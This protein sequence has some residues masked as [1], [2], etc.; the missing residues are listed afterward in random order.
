MPTSFC[1]SRRPGSAKGC[2]PASTAASRACVACSC[3][4]RAIDPVGKARSDT[5]IVLA[6]AE[7][8]G[9]SDRFFDGD[10]D[11]GHDAALA[12]AGVNVAQLRAAPAGIVVNGP[13][14]VGR[15]C[16]RRR[17]QSARLSDAHAQDRALLGASSLVGLSPVARVRRGRRR[18]GQP[19]LSTMP[20]QRQ[21]G[22]LLPQ[23]AS[24]H[25]EPAP[26]RSRSDSWR[27]RPPMPA[28]AA[29]P[30]ATG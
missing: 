5:D 25:R 23:P 19:A 28:H 1:R 24:Q 2:A 9:L 27:S 7:R 17:R 3:V 14:H 4:Q 29:S 6:L 8:L 26:P 18:L 30:T 21:D 16:H 13:R 12:N 11:K 20:R 22:R 15:A 10:V